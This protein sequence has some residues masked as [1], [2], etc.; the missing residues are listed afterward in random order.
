MT[1]PRT[2]P[3]EAADTAAT[4]RT[5]GAAPRLTGPRE[6]ARRLA[7]LDEHYIRESFVPLDAAIDARPDAAEVRAAVADGRL[8]QP[9]Y[10]LDDGTDMVA[11]DY[12]A[13]VDAAGSVEALPGWFA[14]R[15]VR[16]ATRFDQSRD[17]AAVREQWES[18]LSGGYHVCLREV[19]P[20]SIAEK[21]H[22]I[23]TIE[24]LLDEPHPKVTDWLTTLRKAVDELDAIERPGAILDPPR[25]GGPMSPQWYGAYLRSR[26]PRAF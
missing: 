7:E 10:R 1:Y 23:D 13:L 26:Y 9:A 11:A 3:P 4:D 2:Y 22:W 15:Y 8:P 20:E 17:D 19:T 6:V 24:S 5:G 12:F 16:A 18:Y 25:W 21:G 14:E